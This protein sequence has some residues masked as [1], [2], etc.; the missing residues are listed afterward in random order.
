MRALQMT[1]WQSDPE[2]RDVERPSPGPGQVLIRV[3]GAGV[4]H[5]DLHVLY[6]FPA[7]AF[8]WPTPFT[9]GHENAGWVEEVGT[10]V[11]GL[12]AGQPVAVYGPWGCGTCPACSAGA[13]NYCRVDPPG[14]P[15]G[16]LGTDGGM[17][18]YMLVP[19]A[20][21]LVPLPGSL[22]PATAAPLTD[23]G[24]TPFHAVERVR[25][26]L[27]PGSTT[28]VIGAGG[29]G[30]LAVQILLATTATKVIAVDSRPEARALAQAKGADA[31]LDSDAGTAAT[32]RDLTGGQGADAVLDVVGSDA[33]L[34]LAAA[35]A[36]KNSHIV[37]VGIAG[38][39]LPVS[40]LTL[41]YGIRVSTTYWGTRPD[42]HAVLALAARGD[43]VAE[44]TTYPLSRAPEAYA[45]LRAGKVTGRAVVVPDPAS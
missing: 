22:A 4:C 34:A 33:T 31:A 23:A 24:L 35:V 41:P 32:I 1:G 15:V 18:E 30:N 25:D 9:L 39:S 44:T 3:G 29:L 19:A 5:S 45:A 27:V 8:P 43:L 28:V 14:T 12:D 16:G 36:A 21:H 6:E 11:R 2:L 13:E 40:F 20:R 7:G 42:L 38:G 10:G 26:L 37:I 17:A